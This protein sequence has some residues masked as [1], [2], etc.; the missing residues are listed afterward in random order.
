MEWRTF[1][2]E[3]ELK[4]NPQGLPPLILVLG[5]DGGLVTALTKQVKDAVNP[6]SD[7][8]STDSLQAEDILAEPGRLYDAATTIGF[9]AGRRLVS[10]DGVNSSQTKTEMDK[11]IAAVQ[12]CL[13]NPCKDAIIVLSAPEVDAKGKL[14]NMVK[15]SSDGV[16]VRCYHDK[17]RTLAEVINVKL[18][19]EGKKITADARAFLME[20]L[21]NDRRVTESE[22]EKLVLYTGKKELIELNDCLHSLASAPSVNVFALCDAI[23]QRDRKKMDTYLTLLEEEGEE[24]MMIAAMVL[25]HL[26][27][28]KQVQDALGKG[29]AVDKALKSLKP[30]VRFGQDVFMRQVNQYPT[31]RLDALADRFYADQVNTRQS[32]SPVSDMD[33]LKRTL[34]AFCA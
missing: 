21:G 30:P 18:A 9:G 2:L 16:L 6:D 7:P 13:D 20:N 4:S 11:I 33:A 8:F 14:A 17:G 23:G 5:D 31:R 10:V 32:K 25:R 27:R 15:K 34:L 22:L 19:K 28:I 29:Q 24:P 26:R 3:R 1:Q 12:M